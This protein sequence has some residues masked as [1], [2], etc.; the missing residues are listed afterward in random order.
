MAG[1]LTGFLSLLLRTG[2]YPERPATW[3]CSWSRTAQ[4]YPPGLGLGRGLAG[5][6]LSLRVCRPSVPAAGEQRGRAQAGAGGG[7]P[8]GQG[9][10]CFRPGGVSSRARWDPW[11]RT[12]SRT[13][14]WLERS[15]WGTWGTWRG[16]EGQPGAGGSWDLALGTQPSTVDPAPPGLWPC[17]WSQCLGPDPRVSLS[18]QLYQ[19]LNFRVVLVG[20]EIWNSGDKIA[21]SSDPDTTLNNFLAW[22][23]R[24]LASRHLHDNAQLIT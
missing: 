17:H 20:L 2:H 19:E 10:G 7:E 21:I 3:S 5:D 4:R 23:A 15:S 9:G 13:E 18:S 24:D 8:R 22:R 16:R 11:Q 12:P 6:R 1:W 14:T